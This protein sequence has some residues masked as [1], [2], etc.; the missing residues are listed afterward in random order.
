MLVPGLTAVAQGRRIHKIQITTWAVVRWS[1]LPLQDSSLHLGRRR[2]WDDVDLGRCFTL[3]FYW[4]RSLCSVSVT[5]CHF[6]ESSPL[7]SLLSSPLPSFLSFP[8]FSSLPVPLLYSAFF[9]LPSFHSPLLSSP[10]IPLLFLPSPFLSL[11]SSPLLPL[12]RFL[13]VQTLGVCQ[14]PTS[15]TESG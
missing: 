8:P 11:L 12:S 13:P 5:S 9:P 2:S 6:S 10:S 3:W 4:E 14:S 15:L 1:Q 7:L